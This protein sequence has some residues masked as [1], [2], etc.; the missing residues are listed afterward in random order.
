MRI[1]GW[2]EAIT[3]LGL[4]VVAPGAQADEE[5]I[6]LKDVPRAVIDAVK[7]KFPDAKMK[8]AVK[9]EEDGRTVYELSFTHEDKDYEIEAKADGTIVAVEKQ[10]AVSDL[11][12]AVVKGVKAKYPD[13]KIEEAKEVTAGLKVTYEVE[14]ETAKKKELEITLD[15][16]GRI[17][18]TE[19]EDDDN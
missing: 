4:L 2:M 1:F 8:K 17:L 3:A 16:S 12:E 18:K 11:P 13:A 5:E 7:A 14:I 15:A 10:I 9:E 6:P 19:E